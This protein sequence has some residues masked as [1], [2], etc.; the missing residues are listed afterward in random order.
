MNE[1]IARMSRITASALNGMTND[2]I[3]NTTIRTVNIFHIVVSDRDMAVGI[4]LFTG[5]LY[6]NTGTPTAGI[7]NQ[8]K[9]QPGLP[10]KMC[11]RYT[12]R[13]TPNDIQPQTR[14][15]TQ[16]LRMTFRRV[17]FIILLIISRLSFGY[18][19]IED[20]DAGLQIYK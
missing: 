15:G 16:A 19:F 2:E 17:S 1:P 10:V 14:S 18:M 12:I 5:R 20:L 6:R 13:D 3:E 9:S 4:P 7:R 11:P 8:A